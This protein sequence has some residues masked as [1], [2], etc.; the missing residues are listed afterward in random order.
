MIVKINVEIV[1][2]HDG[3]VRIR[4]EVRDCK[5]KNQQ[6]AMFGFPANSKEY[7]AKT[8]QDILSQLP[9]WLRNRF[10]VEAITAVQKTKQSESNPFEDGEP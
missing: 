7:D 8:L 5:E 10:M 2:L 6:M 9:E 3:S 4:H 1:L